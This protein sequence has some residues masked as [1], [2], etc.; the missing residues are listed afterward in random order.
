[1]DSMYRSALECLEEAVFL[2]D[3]QG[4]VAFMN[5]AAQRVTGWHS[6]DA[7]NRTIPEILGK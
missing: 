2:C 3:P 4:R 5:S 7:L 1:M 6:P